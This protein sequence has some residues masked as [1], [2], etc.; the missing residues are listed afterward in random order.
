VEGKWKEHDN[1]G[2]NN[3]SKPETTHIHGPYDAIEA[4]PVR[5]GPACWNGI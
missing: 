5:G 2:E 1:R 4:V 3:S